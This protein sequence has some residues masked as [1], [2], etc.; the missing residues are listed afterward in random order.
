MNASTLLLSPETSESSNVLNY[1]GEKPGRRNVKLTALQPELHVMQ[2]KAGRW[3]ELPERVL[4]AAVVVLV[5]EVV[6]EVV[7]VAVLVEVIAAV[8]T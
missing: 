7:T 1:T 5:V 2:C 6:R 3:N 4:A 8:A